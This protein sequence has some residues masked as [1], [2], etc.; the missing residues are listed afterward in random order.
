MKEE[1]RTKMELWAAAQQKLIE[2]NDLSLDFGTLAFDVLQKT[3]VTPII[4][5]N[6]QGKIIDYK[7]IAWERKTDPDSTVL[8]ALLKKFK[9]QNDPLP[10]VYKDIVNQQLYYGNSPL[11]IKL[12]YYPL[13]L[14]LILLLFGGLLYFFFQTNKAAEQNRLWAGMAKETA[15]QIGTPLS[16]LMGW[17]ALLKEQEVPS[18]S[19][20]EMQKDIERLNVITDR[21]SK[22]GSLPELTLM[23]LR[24]VVNDTIHYLQKRSGK[25][26]EWTIDLPADEVLLPFNAS[27]I[28]WTLE[29]LI[30][31]GLDAMKGEGRLCVRLNENL[32]EVSLE[33][34]DSGTG[35]A[36][37]DIHKIF[38]PGFTTK[39]RGW[40]LGLSL[41]KRIVEDYHR[42]QIG[43]KKT[44]QGKGT[45][46][47][48][49]LPK[50]QSR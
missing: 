22:I 28:S 12:Q 15:H 24:P 39:A 9:Q 14:L 50:T 31:N 30:K 6:A 45:R 37:G 32:H 3:G 38:A 36:A 17:L 19:L 49:H 26:V 16:S 41:A 7:N 10:I 4:Q 40:G 47:V 11:L 29:N 27:L 48:L 2:S 21:F 1:E 8:Y 18:D 35:I 5:V 42:G 34:Q 43:V 25:Q 20:T 44:Q 13:A 33:I 46:F 23:D